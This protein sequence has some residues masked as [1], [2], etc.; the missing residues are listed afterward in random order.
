MTDDDESSLLLEHVPDADRPNV[1]PFAPSAAMLLRRPQ[2][3]ET[4]WYA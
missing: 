4:A 2:Q 3:P 1:G